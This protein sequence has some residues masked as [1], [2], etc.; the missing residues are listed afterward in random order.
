MA[1]WNDALIMS[2]HIIETQWPNYTYNLNKLGL[3]KLLGNGQNLI[4]NNCSV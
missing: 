2:G 1:G 4:Y 3:L